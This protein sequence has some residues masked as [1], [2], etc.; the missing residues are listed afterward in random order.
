[1]ELLAAI[2]GVADVTARASTGLWKLCEQW[3]DTP[4]EIHLLRDDLVQANAFFAQI[5]KGLTA[6]QARGASASRWPPECIRELERLL[7]N[8]QALILGVEK[9]VDELLSQGIAA[10]RP[11]HQSLSGRRKLLWVTKLRWTSDQRSSLKVLMGKICV[12]LVSL[13]V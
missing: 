10:S 7:K 9:M 11:S 5:Q 4:K 12:S 3:R 6:E 8:G 2:V 13:N 1:M